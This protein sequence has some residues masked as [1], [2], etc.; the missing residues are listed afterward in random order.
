MARLRVTVKNGGE[1]YP[2]MLEKKQERK[3]KLAWRKVDAEIVHKRK[4]AAGAEMQ[5]N[6]P[7]I[8]RGQVC[9]SLRMMK[10]FRNL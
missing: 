5:H 10:S 3:R 6:I 7:Y 9:E 2:L 8:N 1:I 4:L